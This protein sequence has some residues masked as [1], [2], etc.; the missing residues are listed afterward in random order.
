[1]RNTRKRG[2]FTQRGRVKAGVALLAA[3]LLASVLASPVG[4]LEL[5]SERE[6]R[7]NVESSFVAIERNPLGAVRLDTTNQ[8]QPFAIGGFSSEPGVAHGQTCD[9]TFDGYAL[10]FQPDNAR[11]GWISNPWREQCG[12]TWTE[13]M[14]TQANHMHLGYENSDI[15]PCQQGLL[16]GQFAVIDDYGN[17]TDFDPL[18]E[19]RAA[20]SS[21]NGAE[22]V[23]FRMVGDDGYEN[24]GFDGI[25]V[26]SV[27]IRVCIYSADIDKI[28]ANTGGVNA[29]C[30]TLTEGYWDL[31]GHDEDASRVTL[32]GHNTSGPSFSFDDIR[33]SEV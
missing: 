29:T 13:V 19:P 6:Y 32:T 11:S 7:P 9:I 26:G 18:T 8:S 28:V 30:G 27:P 31:T 16:S 10:K 1:M 3:S 12:G 15:G 24:F 23:D 25:R 21:H 2:S 22:V 20:M 4:A 17:C 5:R 33:V 14:P